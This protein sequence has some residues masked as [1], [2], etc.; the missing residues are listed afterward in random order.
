MAYIPQ[1]NILFANASV[2]VDPSYVAG[3]S[4]QI[5][6]VV[7]PDPNV[8]I[9]N[10][11]ALWEIGDPGGWGRLE[12][13]NLGQAEFWIW[14]P[15]FG[16]NG[17]QRRIAA[18]LTLLND[19]CYGIVCQWTQS[20]IRVFVIDGN[21]GGTVAEAETAIAATATSN[22][23]RLRLASDMRGAHW[24]GWF[25]SIRVWSGNR[26]DSA[27]LAD[28]FT[29]PVGDPVRYYPIDDGGTTVTEKTG[30]G[31]GITFNIG[32]GHWVTGNGTGCIDVLLAPPPP[33]PPATIGYSDPFTLAVCPVP[34]TLTVAVAHDNCATHAYATVLE[35]PPAPDGTLYRLRLR[36]HDPAVAPANATWTV[37]TASTSRLYSFSA[38]LLTLDVPYQVEA[39]NLTTAGV[40]YSDVFYKAV[41]IAV[42][43][44]P[45]VPTVPIPI[46][47][48]LPPVAG[49]LCKVWVSSL[50]TE[51][52]EITAPVRQPPSMGFTYETPGS[53]A[54]F[55]GF[56]HETQ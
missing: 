47:P 9:S 16:V 28:I 13:N 20:R 34:P 41:C 40:A 43:T 8:Q 7:R 1:G 31:S 49:P 51:T 27:T 24:V 55:V 17:G 30:N 38:D 25:Q 23:Q 14:D 35:D 48:T 12:T 46:S 37:L 52:T 44:D 33:P 42:P 11:R 4:G 26:S 54:P 10:N 18:P 39:T 32:S 22:F 6:V 45:E 50:W 36:I 21:T 19:R 5:E 2:I 15:F 29:P 3:P 53:N 56:D